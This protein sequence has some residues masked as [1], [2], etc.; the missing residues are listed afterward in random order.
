MEY[1]F[2]SNVSILTASCLIVPLRSR[3]FDVDVFYFSQN[4]I[5]LILRVQVIVKFVFA[6]VHINN[7]V[8][9]I[10]IVRFLDKF[11]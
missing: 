9:L 7:E 5:F 10:L 8:F 1:A 11:S 2:L 3:C 4:R 6:P